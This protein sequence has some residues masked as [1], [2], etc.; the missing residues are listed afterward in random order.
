[1]RQRNLL[2]KFGESCLQAIRL[3]NAR[4]RQIH[5][6][7]AES[8]YEWKWPRIASSI[9]S[10]KEHEGALGILLVKCQRWLPR[11]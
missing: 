10:V 1:M 8:E 4:N 9:N 7:A 2:P 11:S 6:Q 3:I 5:F